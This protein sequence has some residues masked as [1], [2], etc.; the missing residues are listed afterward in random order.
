[1]IYNYLNFKPKIHESVF[2]ADSADV[3]GDVRLSKNSS[4]FFNSVLRGDINYISVGK[5]TNIQDSSVVHVMDDAPCIIGDN[6]V[7]GHNVNLHACKI[8]DGSLIGIGAIIL[9]YAEIGKGSIIA[10]GSLI[11]EGRKIPDGV[12]VM[13]TPGKIIREVSD[14]EKEQ[15]INNANHY[16]ELRRVYLSMRDEN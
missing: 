7:I 2:V 9:S 3:I 1:M 12:L 6:V 11:P 5:N 4:V 15:I 8:G 10:A 14:S 16:S 13:G